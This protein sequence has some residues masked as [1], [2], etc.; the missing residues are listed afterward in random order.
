MI[1]IVDDVPTARADT[2]SVAAG[3]FVAATGNVITATGTTSGATGVDTLGAD[4][5]KVSQV[6]S[7]NVPANVDNTATAGASR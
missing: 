1:K 4:S 2:D 3:S 6:A 7:N 5:A